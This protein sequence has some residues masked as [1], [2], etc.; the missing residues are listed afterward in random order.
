MKPS[1]FTYR[2]DYTRTLTYKIFLARK[3]QPD[4]VTTFEQALEI[5]RQ[6][7]R[8]TRGIPQIVYLVGWQYDGHD[9]RYPCWAQVNHRLGRG[10]DADATE[11]LRWLMREAATLQATVS[12]H[13]NMCDAY[14][15]SPLWD[16]YVQKDL[17]NRNPDGSLM[18][19]GIWDGV[20]SYLVSKT[21]EWQAG[22]AQRRIDALVEMLPLTQAGT[23]HIDVFRPCPS[24]FHNIIFADEVAAMIEILHY[25]RTL[26]IDVTQEWFHH[27]FAGL[28]PMVNHFN[29]SEANRLRYPPA[30]ICGGG[31]SWNQ[32]H[33]VV[34]TVK[35]ED[36]W[37]SPDL[38][39]LYEEAW[40]HSLDHDIMGLD[41]VADFADTFYTRT[42]PW[43]FL[44]RHAILRHV[45][46]AASYEVHFADDV[47]TA[48]RKTDRQFH[49]WQGDRL[50]AENADLLLPAPWA[51]QECIAY[52]R[53]GGRRTWELPR[54]WKA[55]TCV[56]LD[57]LT[58]TVVRRLAPQSVTQGRITLD[59][60]P[61]Q[62]VGVRP[63]ASQP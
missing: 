37:P 9:S 60:Q 47:R 39:C 13:I 27:E 28:V 54:D 26:G 56:E 49:L 59:L 48:I 46:T 42:L 36:V 5:I 57:D 12:L 52:S 53:A 18:L 43:H 1:S 21:R 7:H 51:G 29:L 63:A 31:S 2:H 19:G 61:R 62:A 35:G 16:E 33:R 34:N 11:S 4:A 8:L 20:Q 41:F 50:L 6:V 22:L 38:G 14:P 23:I 10:E 55:V 58:P 44:N 32:C 25:W 30:V 3:S 24:P 17:L 15:D 40:G 45:H